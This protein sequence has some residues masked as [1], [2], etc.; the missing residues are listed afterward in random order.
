VS[1]IVSFPFR[2]VLGKRFKPQFFIGKMAG[3]II[4]DLFLVRISLYPYQFEVVAAISSERASAWEKAFNSAEN[5]MKVMDREIIR[6]GGKKP[7]KGPKKAR[8]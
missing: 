2:G 4:I 1:I 8:G 7:R 6:L 5:L 3:G